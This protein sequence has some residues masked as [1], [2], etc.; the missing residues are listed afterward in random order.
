MHRELCSY[1]I[2][3]G[4]QV[5]D[6]YQWVDQTREVLTSYR[7]PCNQWMHT[8]SSIRLL[9]ILISKQL[10][11]TKDMANILQS[12]DNETCLVY[13][14]RS[15]G[16]RLK[17]INLVGSNSE[18]MSCLLIAPTS[19]SEHSQN[20]QQD[21]IFDYSMITHATYKFLKFIIWYCTLW[22]VLSQ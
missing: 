4:T 15:Y 14:S 10:S 8:A 5:T 3:S 7:N 9:R 18:L 22:E 6:A 21:D 2:R 12:P 19:W 1:S 16:H 13:K 20:Y 17:F 11:I